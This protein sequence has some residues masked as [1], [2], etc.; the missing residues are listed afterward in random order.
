[1]LAAQ[2]RENEN[3]RHE[4]QTARELIAQLRAGSPSLREFSPGR[5]HTLSFRDRSPPHQILSETQ[6]QLEQSQ[7][8][9]QRTSNENQ[10]L[11][12]DLRSRIRENRALRRQLEDSRAREKQLEDQLDE[13][14]LDRHF[15]PPR[16]SPIANSSPENSR[17]QAKIEALGKENRTLSDRLGTV[18]QNLSDAIAVNTR[19]REKVRALRRAKSSERDEAK[20]S[21][22]ALIEHSRDLSRQ[23]EES[24][25]FGTDEGGS[26]PSLE[27]DQH[28][29]ELREMCRRLQSQFDAASAHETEWI[30]RHG[31]FCDVVAQLQD[32]IPRLGGLTGSLG[33]PEDTE[34]VSVCP[35]RGEDEDASDIEDSVF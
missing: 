9:G 8:F 15:S 24:A 34:V 18:E 6:A 23:T 32:E 22:D 31:A 12:A 20:A 7:E 30:E 2:K 4:L 13:I 11:K 5:D 1:M 35:P 33:S 16:P 17:L 26:F 19:L 21:I 29:D 14:H 3:L 25:T 28:V 10:Q 27:N